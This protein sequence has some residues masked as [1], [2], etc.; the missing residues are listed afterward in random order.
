MR[1]AWPCCCR[2]TASIRLILNK[3]LGNPPFGCDNGVTIKRQEIE[4]RVL[5]GLREKLL[6]PDL[7]K[8]FIAEFTAET[9]RIRHEHDLVRSQKSRELDGVIKGIA[10]YPAVIFAAGPSA[11]QDGVGCA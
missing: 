6:A 7:V 5:T 10:A 4:E 3:G 9:N 2:P 8:E 11:G 1:C